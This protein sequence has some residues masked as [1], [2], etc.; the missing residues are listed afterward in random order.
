MFITNYLA[1]KVLTN[2]QYI[3]QSQYGDN[4]I[5]TSTYAFKIITYDYYEDEPLEKRTSGLI[6]IEQINGNR[7]QIADT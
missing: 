5:S 7:E 2:R 6:L 1:L 4:F 3:T